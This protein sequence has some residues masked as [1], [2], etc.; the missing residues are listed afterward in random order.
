M[1]VDLGGRHTRQAVW[2]RQ[3]LFLETALARGVATRSGCIFAVLFQEPLAAYRV[4]TL[5][6]S[7]AKLLALALT[8]VFFPVRA[9]VLFALY[10]WFFDVRCHFLVRTRSS[11]S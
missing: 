11:W 4:H 5:S 8:L 1:C 6:L 2:Q 3:H 7:Q 10:C 9:L